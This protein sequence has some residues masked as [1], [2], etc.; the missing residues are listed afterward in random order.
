MASWP[1]SNECVTEQ[2]C[3]YCNA[4]FS[5]QLT[6][7]IINHRPKSPPTIDEEDPQR[8]QT[9]RNESVCSGIDTDCI[10]I[11]VPYLSPMAVRQQLESILI[12]YGEQHCMS[13]AMAKDHSAVFWNMVRPIYFNTPPPK[14][15][16]MPHFFFGGG[17]EC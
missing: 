6:I 3:P 15:K 10:E 13:V 16:I 2:A 11:K 12:E 17:E 9:K 4:S 5:P 8:L 7:H 1:V 14:K